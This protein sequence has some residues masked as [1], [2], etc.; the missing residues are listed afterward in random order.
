MAENYRYCKKCLMREMHD[1]ETFFATLKSH[2]DNIPQERKA[3]DEL[4]E[5]RLQICKECELLL[6]GMCRR[7]GC[8]V[9]LRAASRKNYCP[10]KKW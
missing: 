8:Y 9:E 1:Q 6:E 2:I 10:D 5:Q 4:Y 7:C 3:P